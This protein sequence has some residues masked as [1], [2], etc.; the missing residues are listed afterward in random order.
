MSLPAN[1]LPFEQQGVQKRSKRG[2]RMQPRLRTML[3]RRLSEHKVSLR[4]A[5]RSSGVSTAYLSMFLKGY[6]V[7]PKI[8]KK[9]NLWLRIRP[10][11]KRDR[12]LLPFAAH[13]A[14][15]AI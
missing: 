7:G 11:K 5:A 14:P 2:E 3:R 8:E 9:L 1:I 6:Q 15:D 4:D 10:Y 12:R 13:W